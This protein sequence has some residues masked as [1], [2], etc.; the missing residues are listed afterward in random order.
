MYTE[1]LNQLL[2][3]VDKIISS[4]KIKNKDNLKSQLYELVELAYDSGKHDGFYT[5]IELQKQYNSLK[6]KANNILKWI[7]KLL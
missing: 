3:R 2:N 7:K 6:Y 5:C 4:L 1:N